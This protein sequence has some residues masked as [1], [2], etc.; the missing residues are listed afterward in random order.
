MPCNMFDGATS[1]D[2]AMSEAQKL[3]R[4]LCALLQTLETA[5]LPITDPELVRWW[6]EHKRWDQ[7]QGRR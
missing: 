3:T 2:F 4:M 1:G 5:G 6:N 7:S